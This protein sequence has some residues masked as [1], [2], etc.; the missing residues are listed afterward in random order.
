[1]IYS[2]DCSAGTVTFTGIFGCSDAA[3]VVSATPV[4]Y[5]IDTADPTTHFSDGMILGWGVVAAMSAAYGIH[6]LRR[7]LLR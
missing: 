6:L 5:A 3:G 1:M 2:I 7:S 4:A